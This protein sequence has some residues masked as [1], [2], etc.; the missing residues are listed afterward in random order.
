MAGL[1]RASGYFSYFDP[2]TGTRQEGETR[3]CVHCGATWIYDPK[4]D[5]NRK[6][7]L[8]SAKPVT[9]GTCLSCGGL[10]CA[11][12]D[13]LQRGCVPMMQQ[14]EDMEATARQQNQILSPG[15]LATRGT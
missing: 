12:P 11:L 13:C 1:E 6:F 2:V 7:G 4:A 15:G 3:S 10:V 9:R 8:T 14:I 5:L